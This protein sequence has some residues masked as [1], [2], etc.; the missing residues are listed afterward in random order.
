MTKLA[1]PGDP[2]VPGIGQV[3]VQNDDETFTNG[4]IAEYLAKQVLPQFQR[5]QPPREIDETLTPEADAQQQA[6]I[7]AIV[8]LRIMG[9]PFDSIASMLG[10]SPDHVY[11]LVNQETTQ[12]TFETIF[13]NIVSVQATTTQG[14]I[15]SFAD[16]A[17]NVVVSMMN[18]EKTRDDVRL[19]AAQDVLDRSGT[20]AEQFFAE[21]KE[22]TAQ[23]DEL[24]ITIMNDEETKQQVDV[25][26]KRRGR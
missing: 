7:A 22:P 14:K 9:L 17:V 25:S 21:S 1:E 18:D 23:D 26:F 19:K 24:R 13:K 12:R 4:T 6:G 20:N 3:V 8:A 15:A 11:K 5:F 2:Y 16:N 10:T